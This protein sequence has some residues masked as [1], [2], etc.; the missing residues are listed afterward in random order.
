MSKFSKGFKKATKGV[1]GVTGY[2]NKLFDA[3]GFNIGA[4]P[5]PDNPYSPAD[6]SR[7]FDN[8]K[9]EYLK[10]YAPKAYAPVKAESEKLFQDY[11]GGIKSGYSTEDAQLQSMLRD[12]GRETENSVASSKMDFLDRGLGGPGQMSD[13]EA[14][15]LAQTRG[16]GQELGDAARLNV[17]SGREKTLSDAFAKRYATGTDLGTREAEAGL[18]LNKFYSELLSGR[19]KEGLAGQSGAYAAGEEAKYKYAQ[20]GYLDSILRNISI[21]VKA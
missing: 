1:K 11:L 3:L 7:L 21:G 6:W 15:A 17:L 18:D 10:D 2:G 20:P 12:I 9:F 13:I 16:Q 14:I 4:K 8:S 5:G 19:E